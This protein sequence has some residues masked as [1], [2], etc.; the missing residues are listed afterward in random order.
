MKRLLAALLGS[1]AILLAPMGQA[2]QT[3]TEGS[4]YELLT[5]SQRTTVAPGKVEVMEVF[6]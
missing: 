1:L 5:P 4:N 2:A 3:F 6:S